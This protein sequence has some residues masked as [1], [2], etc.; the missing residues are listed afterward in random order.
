[1]EEI[2]VGID[3]GTTNTLACYLKKGKPTLIKFPGSGNVLPS[4]VYVDEEGKLS[5]GEKAKTWGA[6]DPENVIK[7]SKTYMG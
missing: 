5:V 7:S 1:M 6:V 3:L 2:F 4:V